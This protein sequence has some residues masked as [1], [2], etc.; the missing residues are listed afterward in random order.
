MG[1]IRYIKNSDGSYIVRDNYSFTVTRD[2]SNNG[3]PRI[4]SKK[5]QDPYANR[6]WVGLIQDLKD[7]PVS[8]WWN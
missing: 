5:E 2:F 1:G 7:I 3:N 8:E 4:R 6:Q